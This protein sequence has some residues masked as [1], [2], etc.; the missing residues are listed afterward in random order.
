MEAQPIEH[1]MLAEKTSVQDILNHV[2]S[3]AWLME[4]VRLDPN[5]GAISLGIGEL[6]RE[7]A[8]ELKNREA[9][10]AQT[11]EELYEIY[12]RQEALD[13][14]G[15]TGSRG[16]LVGAQAH[17][18]GDYFHSGNEFS[19]TPDSW[20]ELSKSPFRD[21]LVSAVSEE[22][23]FLQWTARDLENQSSM[24]KMVQGRAALLDSSL[25]AGTKIIAA[26]NP[27]DGR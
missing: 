11:P 9:I 21:P 12:S 24:L 7:A 18:M 1:A 23:D 14:L 27:S 5:M 25:P 15:I 10:F 8:S 20:D 6:Q 13:L 19:G 2:Y 22:Q 4:P 17:I 26:A 16:S 3:P